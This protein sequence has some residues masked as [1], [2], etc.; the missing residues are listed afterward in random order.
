MS[1]SVREVIQYFGLGVDTKVIPDTTYTVMPEDISRVLWFTSNSPISVTLPDF[2]TTA[3]KGGFGCSITQGGDGVITVTQEGGDSVVTDLRNLIT[4][5]KGTGLFLL[6]ESDTVWWAVAQGDTPYDGILHN[7]SAVTDP[8]ATDDTTEGYS[9]GSKW[10]NQITEETFECLDAS[11]GAAVWVPTSLTLDDLGSAALSDAS[12]F[13][14]AAQGATADSALQPNDNISEL[15]NDSGYIDSSGAPVQTV[16]GKTGTVTLVKGDITDF[17]DADYATAA[18]GATADSALQPN[19]NI[20]ELNNDSGF[21]DSSGAPVQT[22]AGKTGAVTL[23]KSDITD[24]NDADYATA[25]Q[26]AT[27]DSAL[28]PSDNISELNNDSGY[29]TPAYLGTSATVNTGTADTE[30]PLNSDLG[31]AAYEHS[32]RLPFFNWLPAHGRFS[33][34]TDFDILDNGVFSVPTSVFSPYNGVTISEAGK[35]IHNN[36]TNGGAAGNLDQSVIDLLNDIGRSGLSA[37]YGVEFRVARFTAG[38][39]TA[40]AVSGSEGDKYPVSVSISQ[41]MT[42]GMDN[43]SVVYFWVRAFGS[44]AY[45]FNTSVN[46]HAVNGNTV[47]ATVY[48][49]DPSEGYV[50]YRS[51]ASSIFGYVTSLP[52]ICC[53]EGD[54]VDIALASKFSG[55]ITLEPYT[56]PIPSAGSLP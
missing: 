24:F 54:G 19:D 17:N 40:G 55:S 14:T 41:N 49:L 38:N 34:E 16:A 7:R 31:S 48:E 20:S 52:R 6:K 56:A 5:G 23:E 12:D 4:A 30:I 27:A 9:V 21:I 29:I 37:R 18:Q 1:K 39:G 51:E 10:Y 43:R 35:F 42:V 50:F 15:T 11:S 33:D 46:S 44:K 3:I 45:L 26:G 25:A 28:Q 47:G 32:P 13:A 53:T 2:A 22:V 36:T 8:T